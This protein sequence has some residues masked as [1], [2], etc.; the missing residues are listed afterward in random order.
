MQLHG[1]CVSTHQTDHTLIHVGVHTGA[2]E[3]LRQLG[4]KTFQLTL[5]EP[6]EGATQSCLPCPSVKCCYRGAN[7]VHSKCASPPQP[8]PPHHHSLCTDVAA[9]WPR[10]ERR[11]QG[12]GTDGLPASPQ[13]EAPK[14]SKEL[15]PRSK[16]GRQG[17]QLLSFMLCPAR[18][19]ARGWETCLRNPPSPTRSRE[20]GKM[21]CRLCSTAGR[22][23]GPLLSP[24]QGSDHSSSPT[25]GLPP[26][27][28]LPACPPSLP[29]SPAERL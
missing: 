4:R 21:E 29:P 23:L 26:T 17:S 20:Q 19:P 10:E 13:T 11:A 16:E 3:R 15:W 2:Q 28:C 24:L 18:K 14:K 22:R 8:P 9:V 7:H 12:Q 1:L 6:Q 25:P 5:H 27:A